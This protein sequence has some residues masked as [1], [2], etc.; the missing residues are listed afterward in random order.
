MKE[1]ILLL[2]FIVSEVLESD[3]IDMSLPLGVLRLVVAKRR[4]TR[5]GL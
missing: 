2:F 3:K 4:T 1:E 5:T